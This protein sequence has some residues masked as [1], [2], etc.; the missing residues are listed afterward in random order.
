M[1]FKN[2]KEGI[3]KFYETTNEVVDQHK[4]TYGKLVT[5]LNEKMGLTQTLVNNLDSFM[6]HSFPDFNNFK[7]KIDSQPLEDSNI[8]HVYDINKSEYVTDFTL[9]NK[10]IIVKQHFKCILMENR[11]NLVKLSN[12]QICSGLEVNKKNQLSYTNRNYTSNFN[13]IIETNEVIRKSCTCSNACN[14]GNGNHWNNA[15]KSFLNSSATNFQHKKETKELAIWIDDYFNIFIPCLRTYLVFNYS[16]FPLYSFYINMDKLNLYH[17]YIEEG[18]RSIMFNEDCPKD[19][20]EF[21]LFKSFID[22]GGDYI[23]S[24]DK[25]NHYKT[26]FPNLLEF[27]QY[28]EN[29]A[30]FKQYQYLSENLEQLSPS[31]SRKVEDEDTMADEQKLFAQSQRIRELEVIN[32]KNMEEIEYLR[33]E[34]TQY[35]EKE[36]QS[37]GLISDYQK[38]LEELNSQ[39]HEEIDNVSNK[40]KEIIRLKNTNLEY[41]NIKNQHKRLEE[42][43]DSIKKQLKEVEENMSKIKT[44]NCTLIDKQTESQQKLLVERN[45]IK[46]LQ[47]TI[48][49]LKYEIES[50]N[51]KIKKLE[52]E[53]ES[54]KEQHILSKSKIDEMIAGMKKN[55]T[56][57]DDQY[58]E[59]LLT[60][61]KEKNDDIKKL[62]ELNASLTSDIDKNKKEFDLLK[63]QISELFKK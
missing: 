28:H 42:T 55:E 6:E 39:L 19:L 5:K 56:I 40:Q 22:P 31:A 27:Y 33:E 44:L 36:H 53:V 62:Q 48:R 61:L 58:Q 52:K 1:A 60:Q 59:I 38:L 47:Q 10:K 15:I 37:A 11:I 17:N 30:F 3:L 13:N 24:Q 2:Q 14:C 51:T 26:L 54:E 23:P 29:L 63:S 25:R 43:N 34:R 32:Q 57:I 35:I 45:N 18:I 8:I 49:D 9:P 16:K 41:S 12:G 50:Y 20:K 4:K 46:E 7:D 21:N